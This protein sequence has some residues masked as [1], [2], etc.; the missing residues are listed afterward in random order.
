M[1]DYNLAFKKPFS[2]FRKLIIGII[3]NIFP[4]INLISYG[5]ILE[6]SDIKRGKQTDEMAEWEDFTGFFVKGLLSFIVILIYSV[7]A[8]IV[9]AISLFAV[10]RFVDLEPFFRQI[11]SMGPQRIQIMTPEKIFSLFDFST[12]AEISLITLFSLMPLLLVLLILLFIAAY[13]SPVA[14]LKYIKTDNF[15]EAFNLN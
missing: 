10:F 6:S 14:V 3:L 4:I 7:P 11:I 5:Y 13:V 8:M 2:D 1:I 12:L 15:S 9:G